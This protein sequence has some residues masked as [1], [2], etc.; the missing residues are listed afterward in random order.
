MAKVRSPAFSVHAKG[1][2]GQ[3]S[4]D[5]SGPLATARSK[6]TKQCDFGAA[7]EAAHAR[8]AALN[9]AW[10]SLSSQQKTEWSQH[11]K[12]HP[13]LDAYC[14]RRS[15][16][17]RQYFIRFNTKALLAGATMLVAPAPIHNTNFI[18]ELTHW[19]PLFPDSFTLQVNTFWTMAPTDFIFAYISRPLSAE[20]GSFDKRRLYF[21]SAT[22]G[23][24]FLISFPVLR[25]EAAYGIK[26]IH[27]NEY[28]SESLPFFQLHLHRLP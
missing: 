14:G 22:G 15:L 10:K 9:I 25:R 1:P 27:T 12:Q 2:L 8:M 26:M 3:T 16:S 4:F 18:N 13:V 17:G 28:F 19:P 23:G 20:A 7:T 5:R 11:A 21:S 24:P 6:S